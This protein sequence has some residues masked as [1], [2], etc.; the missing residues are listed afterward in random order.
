MVTTRGDRSLKRTG[1]NEKA[2]KQ[3]GNVV[4]EEQ[5]VGRS[6]GGSGGQGVMD[7][8]DKLVDAQR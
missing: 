3:I 7:T 1:N 4:E 6:I 5:R 2:A 8:W